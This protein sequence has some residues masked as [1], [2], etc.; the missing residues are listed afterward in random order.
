MKSLATRRPAARPRFES[1]ESRWLMAGDFDSSF[2]SPAIAP[3]TYDSPAPNS[4]AADFAPPIAGA[5]GEDQA[6]ATDLMAFARALAASG[7]KFWGAA[8][9]PFCTQQK[10]LFAD[11]AYYLPFVEATNPDRSLTADAQAAGISSFPTW[12]FPDGTRATGVQSLEALSSRTGIPLP[13]SNVPELLPFDDLTVYSGSP[14]WVALNGFDPN[15]DRLTYSVSTDNPSLLSLQVPEGNRS[16]VVDV[17]SWGKMKFELFDNLVPAITNR[18][19]SQAE[20]GFYDKTTTNNSIVTQAV[21]TG[22]VRFIQLGDPTGIGLASSG[23]PPL[24]DVFDARLQYNTSGLLGLAKS[25]DDTGDVQFFVTDAPARS[26]DFD[27]P[28]FG[29]LTEGDKVRH[30]INGT[31]TVEDKPV[32]DIVINSVDV[33]QD[34]EDAALLITAAPGATGTAHV[35]VTATDPFGHST[36]RTFTV[37]VAADTANGGPYLKRAHTQATVTGQSV[38]WPLAS[39]DVE[40]DAV[41]Y[42]GSIIGGNGQVSVDPTTGQVTV[43]PDSGFTGTLRVLTGVQAAAGVANDTADPLDTQVVNVL[44]EANPPLWQNRDMPLDT[45]GDSLIAPRDAL[46]IIN[47]LNGRAHSNAAGQFLVARP[48]VGVDFLFYDTSGDNLVTPRDALLIINQLNAPTGNGEGELAGEGEG[49][50]VDN[51]LTPLD[52]NASYAAA[53]D[54]AFAAWML[55][56]SETHSKR[57]GGS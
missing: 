2:L 9:C 6:L 27:F 20:V 32:R 38:S 47:E 3:A 13:Q 55:A 39:I 43:T 29:I 10:E 19:A 7:T 57:Q 53:I 45:D 21:Q 11:A 37:T 12:I 34:T 42:I 30:A 26:L 14:R 54:Q 49:E 15:L 16:L 51:M 35:T 25:G 23:L 22:D 24:D 1:L 4:P 50:N 40:G 44:V 56:T 33:V 36:Q 48:E 41:R 5:E 28:I 46:I 31:A 17:R 18:I 8:W 52:D